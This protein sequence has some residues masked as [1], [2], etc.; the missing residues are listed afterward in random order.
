MLLM[1]T[2]PYNF[3]MSTNDNEN[4]LRQLIEAENSHNIERLVSLL[5]D[6][7]II[8][9]IPLGV[10]MK[11]KD[12]VRQGYAGF[13]KVTPDFKIEL[14]SWIT[15]DKLFALEAIFSGTQRGDLPGLPARGKTFSNRVCSFGKFENG[16]MK[17]RRDYWDSASMVKQLVEESK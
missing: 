1:I 16:K 17:E 11:G 15:T 5:T 9:D 4:L 8:E 7:V 12:G 14:K 6:D 10:V 2:Q 3:E 13:L